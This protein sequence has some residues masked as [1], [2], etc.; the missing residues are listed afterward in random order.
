MTEESNAFWLAEQ[1]DALDAHRVG[2]AE[3][4]EYPEGMRG[5]KGQYSLVRVM[6]RA[7]WL[8]P[9]RDDGSFRGASIC[10][11]D[12]RL[13]IAALNHPDTVISLGELQAWHDRE[14]TPSVLDDPSPAMLA[15]DAER[16]RRIRETV[17]REQLHTEAETARPLHI[18]QAVQDFG[19]NV[20]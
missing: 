2:D 5:F 1:M 14:L 10:S 6:L 3:Q 8:W 13:R 18:S 9:R 15:R 20:R 12:G 16:R 17:G 4:R 7:P 11:D 19:E